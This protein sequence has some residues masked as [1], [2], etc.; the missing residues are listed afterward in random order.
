MIEN[1]K[2][3]YIKLGSASQKTNGQRI[4]KLTQSRIYS[5]LQCVLKFELTLDVLG[6][7]ITE[8]CKTHY[9]YKCNHQKKHY[10]QIQVHKFCRLKK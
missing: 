10:L 8:L 3:L 6:F 2:Y 5:D 7:R 4:K 1:A 9:Y